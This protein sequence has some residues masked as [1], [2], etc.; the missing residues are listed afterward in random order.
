VLLVL[1]VAVD[2]LQ[3]QMVGIDGYGEIKSSKCPAS[4]NNLQRL[5]TCIAFRAAVIYADG[6]WCIVP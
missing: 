2:G 1:S 5:A 6:W 3:H 4:S